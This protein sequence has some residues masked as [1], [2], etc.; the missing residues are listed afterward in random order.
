MSQNNSAVMDP[1]IRSVSLPIL[2]TTARI[3]RRRI[4]LISSAIAQAIVYYLIVTPFAGESN[5]HHGIAAIVEF[6]FLAM[7]VLV[8]ACEG[9]TDVRL[10]RR[11]RSRLIRGQEGTKWLLGLFGLMYYILVVSGKWQLTH[12]TPAD[13]HALVTG[14][15]LLCLSILPAYWTTVFLL[16][17]AGRSLRGEMPMEAFS[18]M[19]ENFH[20]HRRAIVAFSAGATVVIITLSFGLDVFLKELWL[21]IPILAAGI[22]AA[23]M[24]SALGWIVS[25]VVVFLQT[26]KA[27]KPGSQT[28][29]SATIL[30]LRPSLP[31]KTL[32]DRRSGSELPLPPSLRPLSLSLS[33]DE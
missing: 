7:W 5:I 3:M 31:T 12:S 23:V 21:T 8:A 25:A 22:A 20:E 14:I 18:R 26:S 11:V 13:P 1:F 10:P 27:R 33:G 6:A 9:I 29:T 32:T 30:S 24:A 15:G 2:E 4:G 19:R 16:R 17:A 28:R